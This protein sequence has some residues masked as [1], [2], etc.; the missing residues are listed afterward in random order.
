MTAT[1]CAQL[2]LAEELA[3]IQGIECCYYRLCGTW[4]GDVGALTCYLA[5][6]MPNLVK[7]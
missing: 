1:E 2:P 3:A 6:K 5:T 7:R 4:S